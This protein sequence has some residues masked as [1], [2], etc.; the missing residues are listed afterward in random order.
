MDPIVAGLLSNL[1]YSA[2]KSSAKFSF[3]PTVEDHLDNAAQSVAEEYSELEASDL[4]GLMESEEMANHA[5]SF[6]QGQPL[7][8]EELAEEL[9]EHPVNRFLDE[10]AASVIEE[11]LTAF[12]QELAAKP[13]LWRQIVLKYVKAQR[14]SAQNVGSGQQIELQTLQSAIETLKTDIDALRGL[15]EP[16]E[17]DEALDGLRNDG[18]RLIT[19][20]DFENGECEPENCWRRPFYFQ[21]I[22]AGYAIERELPPMDEQDRDELALDGGRTNVVRQLTSNLRD[23]GEQVVVG[24]PGSGKSTLL[25]TVADRWDQDENTGTILYRGHGEA[26]A[27]AMDSADDFIENVETVAEQ[28]GPVLVIIEDAAR[29]AT[30]PLFEAIYRHLNDDHISY[31]LDSRINEWDDERFETRLRRNDAIDRDSAVG[32]HIWNTFNEQIEQVPVPPLD[33]HE[34][35]RIIDKFKSN[36]ESDEELSA[37]PE[38]VF[39]RIQSYR[40]VSSMLLL[41]Y[42]LP[43][44]GIQPDPSSNRSI[45]EQN[46]IEVYDAINSP[47]ESDRTLVPDLSESEQTL[48]EQLGLT[49]ATLNLMEIGIRRELLLTL[50]STQE[51]RQQIDDFLEALSG[52]FVFGNDGNPV[53]FTPRAVV[54]SL[55][56]ASA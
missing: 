38:E 24:N 48:F 18:F 3:Q 43:V 25:K 47:S 14:N 1:G 21:E 27:Y 46:V 51:E 12:E 34:V 29:D 15:V 56:Q 6:N 31:L 11:F 20:T 30:I 22:R 50:A 52:A 40:G 37:T 9:E 7:P 41:V 53:L 32:Q 17:L 13:E 54:I 44:G 33:K 36:T 39:D 16:E 2:I 42:Y 45:L 23:G 5:E 26:A 28:Q 10:N 8:I 4:L 35:E 19:S 55:S 49:I